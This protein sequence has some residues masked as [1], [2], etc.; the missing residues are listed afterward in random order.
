MYAAFR[1]HSGAY[2]SQKFRAK[3]WCTLCLTVQASLWGLFGFYLAGGW[4]SHVFPLRIQ[5][6]VLGFTYA[7][8]L[9]ALN[10]VMPRFENRQQ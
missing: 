1:I 3:A 6:F 8:V 5:F 2:G 4:L 7:G 10:S 9:L